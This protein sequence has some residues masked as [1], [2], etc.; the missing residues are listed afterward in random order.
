MT[1]TVTKL[2]DGVDTLTESTDAAVT[3][4]LQAHVAS[5]VARV[6]QARPIHQRDPFFRE[7]LRHLLAML[8]IAN[9]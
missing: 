4:M 8:E 7:I 2:D 1:R 3:R 9:S 5:M 6:E